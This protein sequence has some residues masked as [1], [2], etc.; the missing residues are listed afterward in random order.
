MKITEQIIEEIDSLSEKFKIEITETEI[1]KVLDNMGYLN[2]DGTFD[3]IKI[4][5]KELQDCYDEAKKEVETINETFAN[6]SDFA[7]MLKETF[8]ADIKSY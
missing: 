7:N 3:F 4:L 6:I 8:G 2:E 5:P 1:K